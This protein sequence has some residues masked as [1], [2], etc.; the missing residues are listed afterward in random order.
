M[1]IW[2]HLLEWLYVGDDTSK[3]FIFLQIIWVLEKTKLMPIAFDI[4]F[5]DFHQISV[6]ETTWTAQTMWSLFFNYLRGVYVMCLNDSFIIWL[7]NAGQT[8]LQWSRTSFNG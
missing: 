4:F 6:E 8:E 3:W 1:I 2:K 5:L 7:K